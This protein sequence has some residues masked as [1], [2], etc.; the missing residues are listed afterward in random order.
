VKKKFMFLL[1]ITILLQISIPV[2]AKAE[3]QSLLRFFTQIYV[4][5]SLYYPSYEQAP[6]F[7][8]VQEWRNGVLYRGSIPKISYTQYEPGKA[9]VRY[10]G[11]IPYD[12]SVVPNFIMTVK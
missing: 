5:R 6:D 1:I 12:P 2:L 10:G 9:L 7:I 8:V 11:Y 4:E 3:E